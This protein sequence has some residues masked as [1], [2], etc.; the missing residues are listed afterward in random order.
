MHTREPNWRSVAHG[1]TT[2]CPVAK[3]LRRSERILLNLAI[4]VSGKAEKNQ[5]FS[6][7]GLTLGVGRYGARIAVDLELRTGQN[8]VIQRVGI[9]E[10][11]EAQ[12]VGK[13]EDRPQGR[14]YG[15]KLL[16]PA[17]TL[18]DITFPPFV[19]SQQAVVR[20]V[21]RC[22]ACRR[23]EVAYLNDFETKGFLAHHCLARLCFKCGVW[24]TWNRPYG[25]ML[26]AP[27]FPLRSDSQGQNSE[28]VSALGDHDKHSHGRI[29][30]EAVGCIRHPPLG[31]EIV[32]VVDLAP[33]GLRFCS[34]NNYSEG[35][36]V[37]VAAPYS[38]KAPN[39]FAPARIVSY[40]KCPE[41]AHTE[42]GMTYIV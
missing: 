9:D 30:L 29:R 18:W 13:I 21:L 36:H 7:E 2:T 42:Y 33:G 23:L 22:V 32:L 34:A 10:R 31:D 12:V 26:T 27:S 35:S 40:R 8:I 11:A 1:Q 3:N 6:K 15:I 39:I 14:V 24:T 37:E 17:V 4:C 41:N 5:D 25:E 19:E 38:S 16:E 20:V 28:P